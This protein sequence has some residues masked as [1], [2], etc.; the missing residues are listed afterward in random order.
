MKGLSI[1]LAI[2]T[3]FITI[4][5]SSPTDILRL[6][7]QTPRSVPVIDAEFLAK[8]E[9]KCKSNKESPHPDSFQCV[10]DSWCGGGPIEG[11]FC[12]YVAI[13]TRSK[14]VGDHDSE[15]AIKEFPTCVYITPPTEEWASLEN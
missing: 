4:A 12:V 1:F 6:F 10:D 13:P 7:K 2:A 9:A 14:E 5:D 15:V 3:T 8:E 11:C